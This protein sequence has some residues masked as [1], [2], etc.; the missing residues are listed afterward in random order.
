ML[1]LIEES[2]VNKLSLRRPGKKFL[3]YQKAINPYIKEIESNIAKS[4]DGFYRIG[5]KT[6]RD[7]LG[8]HLRDNSIKG[9]YI[10]LQYCLWKCDI[11]I[12]TRLR[13][14]GKKNFYFR[15]RRKSD[16]LPISFQDSDALDVK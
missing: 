6:L 10:G 9:I 12:W 14:D 16:A 5:E 8:K 1:D 11:V 15:R 4:E 7:M 13:V 3:L 2:E